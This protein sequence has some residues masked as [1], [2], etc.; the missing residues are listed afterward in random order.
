MFF[1]LSKIFWVLVKPLNLLAVLMVVG[2]LLGVRWKKAG[3]S[4]I[5]LS[6][7]LFLILGVL[8]VGPNMMVYLERQY[9]RPQTLPD[10]IDGMIVLGGTFHGYLSHVHDYPVA[11]A[12][13]ERVHDLIRLGREHPEAKLVFSGGSGD[14]VKQD[15]IEAPV[16]EQFFRDMGMDTDR[17]ILEPNSRNTYQNA[18][19]SYDLLKPQEGENWVLITSAFHMPRALAVFEKLGWHVIPYPTDHNTSLKYHIW[20][21]G[22]MNIARNFQMLET[23]VKEWIGT[24]IYYLTG[25]STLP[26]PDKIVLSETD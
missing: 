16:V 15:Y 7:A 25:K 4:L 10:R 23:S 13:A 1:I 8:P 5:T 19:Y 6:C 12:T 22:K 14:P 3:R 20:P 9:E 21:T 17:L 2:F 24:G 18:L 26:F 11:F